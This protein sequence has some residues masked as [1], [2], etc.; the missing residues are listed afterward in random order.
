MGLTNPYDLEKNLRLIR[1]VLDAG[2]IRQLVLSHDVC[3][4]SDLST[5][6]GAGYT[7][8]S[9]QLPARLHEIGLSDEQFH[10]LMI[11]NPRRALTGE[12]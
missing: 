8:L 3:Y 4:R 6:G 5:Y 11:D 7:Y 12:D 9:S 2:L 10:Q 1:A